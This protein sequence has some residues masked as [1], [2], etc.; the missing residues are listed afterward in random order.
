[1]SL[2]GIDV[3]AFGDDSQYEIFQPAELDWYSIRFPATLKSPAKA[4]DDGIDSN[5]SA[6]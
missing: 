5:E 4:A 1:V 6:S 2:S 3:S